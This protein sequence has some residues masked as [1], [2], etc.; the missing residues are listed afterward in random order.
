MRNLSRTGDGLMPLDFVG[1]AMGLTRAGYSHDRASKES[2][3][4]SW[5]LIPLNPETLKP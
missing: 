4:V 3:I 1:Q 5:I 2:A